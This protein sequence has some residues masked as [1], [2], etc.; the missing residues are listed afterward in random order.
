MMPHEIPQRTD[1]TSGQ[2]DG[3][4]HNDDCIQLLLLANF[5]MH[6]YQELLSHKIALYH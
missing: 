1:S 3:H 6:M 2:P 5:F 4:S